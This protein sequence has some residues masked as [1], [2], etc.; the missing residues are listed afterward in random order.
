MVV[1]KLQIEEARTALEGLLAVA[2]GDEKRLVE[3]ALEDWHRLAEAIDTA[4]LNHGYWRLTLQ[5]YS[6]DLAIF[7]KFEASEAAKGEWQLKEV[8]TGPRV[9]WGYRWEYDLDAGRL[10]EKKKRLEEKPIPA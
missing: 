5:A 8:E 2:K 6:G 4:L 10:V 9:W 7:F 3:A 1:H